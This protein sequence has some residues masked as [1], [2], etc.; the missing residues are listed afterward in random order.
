MSEAVRLLMMS[1]VGS[2]PARSKARETSY[3]QLL[4]G[5]TGITVRGRA[6]WV[7]AGRPIAGRLSAGPLYLCRVVPPS[8]VTASTAPTFPL[9]VLPPTVP[10]LPS[11]SPPALWLRYGNTPSSGRSHASCSQARS[12]FSP[13]AEN[14]YSEVV[15]PSGAMVMPSTSSREAPGLSSTIKEPYAGEKSLSAACSGSRETPMPLPRQLLKSTSAA[16]P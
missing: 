1:V 6:G 14:V 11:E 4:P 9:V 16:P 10:A 5:K 13:H 7:S 12:I 8:N 2:A 3:S 15:A